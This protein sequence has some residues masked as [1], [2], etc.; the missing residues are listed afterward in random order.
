MMPTL[1]IVIDTSIKLV[2]L[3]VLAYC[4]WRPYRTDAL[5]QRLFSLRDELFDLA[6]D[7]RIAFDDP[8]YWRLRRTINC[9]IRFGHR[10]SLTR[11]IFAA[12]G[13]QG[14]AF[15]RDSAYKQWNR[16]LDAVESSELRHEIR[17]IHNGMVNIV[18]RHIITGCPLLWVVLGTLWVG[19]AVSSILQGAAKHIGAVE[20]LAKRFPAVHV[21]EDEAVRTYMPRVA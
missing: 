19:V 21:L 10:L 17:H 3:W 16:D 2:L 15:D 14:A 11:L 12:V 18:V 9:M 4:F 20:V 6:A 5:R 1:A 8:A 13:M 7:G